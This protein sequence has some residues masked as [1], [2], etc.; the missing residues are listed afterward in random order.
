MDSRELYEKRKAR[1]KKLSIPLNGFLG[2]YLFCWLVLL[3]CLSIPLNGFPNE[4]KVIV[5]KVKNT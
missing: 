3:P 2:L 1:K 4:D 5:I